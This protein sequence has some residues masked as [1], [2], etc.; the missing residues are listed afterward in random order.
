MRGEERELKEIVGVLY[1]GTGSTPEPPSHPV[2]QERRM[3]DSHFSKPLDPPLLLEG[4]PGPSG[5]GRPCWG[6]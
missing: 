4:A 5:G 3:G 6:S 2:Q 1:S